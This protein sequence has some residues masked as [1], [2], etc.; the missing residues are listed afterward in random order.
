MQQYVIIGNGIA[1]ISAAEAIRS[2]DSE[3]NISIIAGEEFP[4]YS[5]PMISMVLEGSISHER[6]PIRPQNFYEALRIE[7]LIGH[8]AL[9]IDVDQKQVATDRGG[10]SGTIVCSSPAGQTQGQSRLKARTWP[11]SATF[12]PK[13]TRGP[14]CRPCR[15]PNQ[16]S[17]WGRFS[18]LQSCLRAPPSRH[19][20]DDADPFRISPFHATR[21]N[22]GRDG[23]GR[24]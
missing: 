5:R 12:A 22:R 8:R 9:A 24:A 23:S 3:G 19:Q 4:P 15:K 10:R 1:G 21:L 14:W 18:W 11:M 20:G 2:L 6:L 13:R 7:A 16:L 17:C